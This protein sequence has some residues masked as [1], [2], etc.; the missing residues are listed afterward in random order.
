MI[1]Y[2]IIFLDYVFLLLIYVEKK[3]IMEVPYQIYEMCGD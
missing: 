2:S 1:D 3:G